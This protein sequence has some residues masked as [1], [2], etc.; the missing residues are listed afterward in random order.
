MA[1]RYLEFLEGLPALAGLPDSLPSEV[2]VWLAADPGTVDSILGG[3]PPEWSAAFAVPSTNE[4][5]VP[6]FDGQLT[7]VGE[8]ARILR[9][10]WA[11]LGLHQY[12][13]EL[14][15]PRWFD[16][17]YAE[18]AG[19]WDAGEAWRL[20]VLLAARSLPS[21]DSLSFMWPTGATDARTAYLLSAT[22]FEYLVGASG[23]RGLQIFLE[24]WR[25]GGSFETALRGTY[26]VTSGQLEED[27]REFVKDRYGWLYVL[28]RS[29]VF[30]SMLSVL[31]LAMYWI[32]RRDRRRRMEKL[33][34]E[35][36]P[37]HPAFWLGEDGGEADGESDG[38][39]DVLN[40]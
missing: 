18:W 8:A 38:T 3:R 23:E 11:H 16:E 4:L 32:R 22:V 33:S 40:R 5:V 37:D 29:I 17:G 36:L 26:G 14:R 10:E 25:D 19:G 30:W 20:R 24:R 12:L 6:T 13:G 39:P 31:L 9:H 28:S 2:T 35:E 7:R 27:W 1:E 15:V 21:L 34:A